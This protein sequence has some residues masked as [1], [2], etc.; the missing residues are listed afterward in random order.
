MDG[1]LK[2]ND[3]LR[4]SQEELSRTK[5]RLNTNN[6]WENP[7]DIYKENP[8]RLLNWNYHNNK[9]YRANQI[10]IGLV[11]LGNDSYL[12][13]T[14]GRIVRELEQ[15][16]EDG[17]GVEYETLEQF[18]DLFG[19]VVVSYHNTVQQLFRNADSIIDDLIVKEILPSVFTGFDFPGYQNVH[20]T[21]KELKTIIN[22]NY[23]SYR[24]NLLSSF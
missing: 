11:Y 13:F 14:V 22:G 17:I 6:G 20:L 15:P 1:K 5:V 7:I 19:R 9:R 4:L 2:L 18:S 16:V 24:N 3:L 12:L 10:S 21:F 23:P 8:K